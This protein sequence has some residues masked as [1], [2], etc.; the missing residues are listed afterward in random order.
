MDTRHSI[1]TKNLAKADKGYR[2]FHTDAVEPGSAAI[3]LES[4]ERS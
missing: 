3:D 4:A 1:V 2:Q